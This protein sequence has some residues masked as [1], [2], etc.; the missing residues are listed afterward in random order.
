[1]LFRSK[2]NLH[3]KIGVSL[4]IKF[5]GEER[6]LLNAVES[7]ETYDDCIDATNRIVEYMKKQQ[8]E[9]QAQIPEYEFSD[10]NDTDGNYA[11]FDQWDESEVDEEEN[12][13]SQQYRASEGGDEESEIT[14]DN[15]GITQGGYETKPYE[16]EIRSYTDEAYKSNESKLFDMDGSKYLYLNVPK[17]DLDKA[18]FDYKDLWK[19]YKSGDP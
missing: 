8:E 1:M 17:I 12:G 14:K 19:K 6:E 9:Q 13:N 4:G 10:E 5:V 2:I 7:A 15:D 11:D 3:T 18:I 16:D